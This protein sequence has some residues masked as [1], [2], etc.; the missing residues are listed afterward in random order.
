MNQEITTT[1]TTDQIVPLA[2]KCFNAIENYR[3]QENNRILVETMN[4][5]N[6]KYANRRFFKKSLKNLEETKEYIRDIY[7]HSYGFLCSH[8]WPCFTG[9]RTQEVCEKI[10]EHFENSKDNIPESTYTISIDTYNS[11]AEWAREQ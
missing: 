3:E 7:Q 1:V 6:K 4:E 2:R 11:I 10:I 9:V 5:Y 8:P